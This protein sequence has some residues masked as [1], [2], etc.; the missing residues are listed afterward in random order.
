MLHTHTYTYLQNTLKEP[1]KH[2]YRCT[3]TYTVHV[4]IAGSEIYTCMHCG[5]ERRLVAHVAVPSWGRQVPHDCSMPEHCAG[6]LKPI[7]KSCVHVRNHFKKRRTCL[8]PG[9]TIG[10]EGR[11]LVFSLTS[12]PTSGS[13]FLWKQFS[14]NL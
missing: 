7:R 14:K 11:T 8:R 12:H 1:L 3:C 10:S 9:Q 2:H 13:R 4:C 5:G 6:Q